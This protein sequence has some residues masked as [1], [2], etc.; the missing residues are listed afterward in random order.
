MPGYTSTVFVYVAPRVRN[1]HGDITDSQLLHARRFGHA[2]T[3]F[4]EYIR[5]CERIG[6]DAP[7]LMHKVPRHGEMPAIT[8]MHSV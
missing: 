3:S 5:V 1:A 2:P 6:C 8:R 7:V 4:A